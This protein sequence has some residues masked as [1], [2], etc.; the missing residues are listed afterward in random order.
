MSVVSSQSVASLD[1]N[2]TVVIDYVAS[3]IVKQTKE[4]LAKAGIPEDKTITVPA[5]PGHEDP[6]GYVAA[7]TFVI[8]SDSNFNTWYLKPDDQSHSGVGYASGPSPPPGSSIGKITAIS[9]DK[10]LTSLWATVTFNSDNSITVSMADPQRN[11]V[12]SF[13][14]SWSAGSSVSSIDGYLVWNP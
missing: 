7:A 1:H 5:A 2:I 6:P 11:P 12:G 4:R 8:Y 10:L 9:I 13:N 14:G 3:E